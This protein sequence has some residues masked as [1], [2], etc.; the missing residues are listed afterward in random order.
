MFCE[1]CDDLTAH[2][3]DGALSVFVN[4]HSRNDWELYSETHYKGA[5][6]ILKPGDTYPNEGKIS[7]ANSVKSFKKA[8]DFQR[9]G[10]SFLQIR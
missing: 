7:L 4:K 10:V 8:H 9:G 1:S 6:I 2:F 5:K 3:P